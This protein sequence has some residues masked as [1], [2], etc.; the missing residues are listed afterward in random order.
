MQQD[1]EYLLMKHK[2][3]AYETSTMTTQPKKELT[4]ANSNY[5]PNIIF[6]NINKGKFEKYKQ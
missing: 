2:L 3:F 4:P 1:P 5:R 6:V